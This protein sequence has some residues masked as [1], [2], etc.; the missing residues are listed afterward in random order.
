MNFLLKEAKRDGSFGSCSTVSEPRV[1]TTPKPQVLVIVSIYQG[2]IWGLPSIFD[3][4]SRILHRCLDVRTNFFPTNGFCIEPLKVSLLA[5]EQK[6]TENC[7]DP[8]H[9]AHPR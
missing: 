6:A 4:H 1:K 8:P 5:G 7:P 9:V 2:A 3:H